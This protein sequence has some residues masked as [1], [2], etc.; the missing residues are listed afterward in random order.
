MTIQELK[1]ASGLSDRE[2]AHMSGVSL[3]TIRRLMIGV[4]KKPQ[5]R[6]VLRLERCLKRVDE[7][8]KHHAIS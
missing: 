4:T 5:R 7:Y 3:G 1:S 8:N 2:L 6:T